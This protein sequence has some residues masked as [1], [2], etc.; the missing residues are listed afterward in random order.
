METQFVPQVEDINRA[1]SLKNIDEAKY[2]PSKAA[3]NNQKVDLNENT[4]KL[5]T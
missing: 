2:K 1:R 4:L 3:E 5:R